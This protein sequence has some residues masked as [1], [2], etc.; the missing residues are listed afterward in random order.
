MK[1]KQSQIEKKNFKLHKGNVLKKAEHSVRHVAHHGITKIQ[2]NPSIASTVFQAGAAQFDCILRESDMHIID[3]DITFEF[4]FDVATNTVTLP[5]TSHWISYV[6]IVC[7]SNDR[8]L[9]RFYNDELFMY[10]YGLITGNQMSNISSLEN[11][12]TAYA[13]PSAIATG[14]N[15]KRNLRIPLNLLDFDLDMHQLKRGLIFR[16]Q[17]RTEVAYT[18]SGVMTLN[19]INMIIP[20]KEFDSN[21]KN[22]HR[23][24]HKKHAIRHQYL[25]G[26][27]H[28]ELSYTVNSST[29]Y[30]IPLDSFEGTKS[31]GL[32]VVIKASTTV[33]QTYTALSASDSTLDIVDN[34]NMSKFGS[35]YPVN[36][37]YVRNYL[38]SKHFDDNTLSSNIAMYFI[39]FCEDLKEASDGNMSGWLEF[40]NRHNLVINTGA[41]W[42]NGTYNVYIYNQYFSEL[43]YKQQKIVSRKL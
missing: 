27:Q 32:L 8:T 14:T 34:S 26:Q 40:K 10:N 33:P 35:G 39:P 24:M 38:G 3:G 42:S 19:D 1:L 11:I 20:E 13:S 2:V 9:R 23:Q 5:S 21:D 43:E 30:K 36:S 15:Y 37:G 25:N 17:T 12:T 41:S 7:R 31:A 6:D 22:I 29:E 4:D 18:G 16:F 28:T